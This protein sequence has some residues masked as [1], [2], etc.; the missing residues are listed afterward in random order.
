ME[1]V[2]EFEKLSADEQ[3]EL[4]EWIHS[5]I[6]PSRKNTAS[7]YGLKQSFTSRRFYCT[8]EVFGQAMERCGYRPVEVR[9]SGN[10]SFRAAIRTDVVRAIPVRSFEPPSPRRP[11]P[12]HTELSFPGIANR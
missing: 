6:R 4:I 2:Y 1:L 11:P 9:P 7:A 5:V 8:Q 10:R 3:R 12:P